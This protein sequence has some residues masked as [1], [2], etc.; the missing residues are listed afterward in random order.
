MLK[1]LFLQSVITIMAMGLPPTLAGADSAGREGGTPATAGS[2]EE[3]SETTLL[4]ALRGGST[5]VRFRYRYEFVADEAFALDAHASTL[6]TTL[7]YDTLDYHGLSAGVEVENVRPI[8]GELYNNLGEGHLHNGQFGRPVVADP[9]LTEINQAVLR[10]TARPGTVA[11]FGR[12]EILFDDQRFVGP[13]G[14]RQNQQ[15]FDAARLDTD[16]LPK[17]RLTYALLH[18]VHRITGDVDP[19]N[20][21]LLHASF[22]TRGAGAVVLYAHALDYERKRHRSATTFGVEITGT[23]PL[24]A[25][26]EF[27]YEVE[28]A[29]QHGTFGNPTRLEAG[30]LHLAGGGRYRGITVRG[31]WERLGGSPARGQFNTPLATLHPFNGWADKFLRTPTDGLDDAY[32]R[33]I[34]D[35][36]P[37]RWTVSYHDFSAVAQDLRH[38]RELDLE[39]VYRTSWDQQIAVTAARYNADGHSTDTTKVMMWTTLGF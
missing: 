39:V 1:K 20:G 25:N 8:G 38:G 37:V 13:V 10:F 24:S 22:G 36:G 15:S 12:Q 19:L 18:N 4:D 26:T 2:D 27:S 28:A 14:W 34:G 33:A 16:L 5:A 7:R 17:G 3:T 35:V 9:G 21:H 29:R 32:V 11:T 31:G 23:R 30:Y 6:R